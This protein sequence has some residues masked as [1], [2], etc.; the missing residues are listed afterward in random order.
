MADFHHNIFYY[1]SGSRQCKDDQCDP[2]LENN[3][4]K[5]LIN[6]LKYCDRKVTHKFLAWL[7]IHS[8]SKVEYVFQK[9]TIGWERIRSAKRKR[10]LLGITSKT[11]DIGEDVCP[12]TSEE[13][14]RPDA[15]LF[16]D[17]FVILI[18]SKIGAALL[19]PDQM[20]RH[21]KTLQAETRK[22][23]VR[24]DITWSEI[25]KFFVELL[26]ELDQKNSWLIRQFTQYLEYQ[27]MSDFVGFEEWMFEFFVSEEKDGKDKRIM[28]DV[29]TK[30]GQELLAAGIQALDPN[31]YEQSWPGNLSAKGHHFW[32][33]FV[34][35]GNP[36]SFVKKVHQTVSL[37]E[38]GL[39][40]F[41]NFESQ[42]TVNLLRKRVLKN[43]EELIKMISK[44]PNPFVISI[45]R[46]VQRKNQPMKFDE[47]LLAEL[48]GGEFDSRNPGNYGLKNQSSSSF[49]C[50]DKLLLEKNEKTQKYE[51]LYMRISR[52]INRKTLISMSKGRGE[53]LVKMVSRM[54][55]EFHPLV[56]FINGAEKKRKR[57]TEQVS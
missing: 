25:H 15:W 57:K 16:G 36:R 20:T 26:P 42:H 40:V 53:K 7:G 39:D 46:K 32:V 45:S 52:S 23:P 30:F 31:L 2:Q 38:Q 12:V 13:D 22:K 27:G 14:S 51:L 18:E 1:Y 21:F 34:P 10:L 37:S 54:L 3:T 41:I 55:E 11:Q 44:L 28:R 29:M 56:A 24:K 49:G 17:D 47:Y 43:R 33:A 19:D 35:K 5:A 50:F 8:T 4:T 48:K 6:T 9:Q